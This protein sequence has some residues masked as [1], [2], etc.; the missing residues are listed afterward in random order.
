MPAVSKTKKG[1]DV[2]SL[3]EELRKLKASS[4]AEIS[5]LKE[6]NKKLNA[7]CLGLSKTIKGLGSQVADLVGDLHAAGEAA[8]NSTAMMRSELV[9]LITTKCAKSIATPRDEDGLHELKLKCTVNATSEDV[10]A[11]GGHYG[12]DAMRDTGWRDFGL[13][14]LRMCRFLGI[15]RRQTFTSKYSTDSAGA[16]KCAL[17][18]YSGAVNFDSDKR[19]LNVE[20]LMYPDF[21]LHE[22]AIEDS[23]VDDGAF[24]DHYDE[25]LRS[26]LDEGDYY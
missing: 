11:L 6:E 4:K 14:G 10:I 24:F 15:D 7:R 1:D 9:K 3:K 12:A 22:E 20:L 2:K 21:E 16:K 5:K 19:S 18:I 17:L 13:G 26:K 23:E 25:R 8:G